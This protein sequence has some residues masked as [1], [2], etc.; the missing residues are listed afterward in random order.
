M[1]VRA[2]QG[3]LKSTWHDV[4]EVCSTFLDEN[5]FVIFHWVRMD[6]GLVGLRKDGEE[7]RIK[8]A[9]FERIPIDLKVGE[10][11]HDSEGRCT[12]KLDYSQTLPTQ[13]DPASDVRG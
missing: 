7:V 1:V 2:E 4:P 11:S 12:T 3:T 13:W 10:D 6:V 8:P 5:G 9:P